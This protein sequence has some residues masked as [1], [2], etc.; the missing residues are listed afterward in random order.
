MQ[1]KIVGYYNYIPSIEN[2]G[3]P[4]YSLIKIRPFRRNQWGGS[5]FSYVKAEG[6][7]CL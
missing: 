2:L 7:K 1:F 4:F 3:L 6:P 5:Y